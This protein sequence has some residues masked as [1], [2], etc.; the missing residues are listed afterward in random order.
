MRY[1]APQ[2]IREA[3]E[4]DPN[5]VSRNRHSL[6]ANR[7]YRRR[8]RMRH[9]LR[10]ALAKPF[11]AQERKHSDSAFSITQRLNDFLGRTV[12]MFTPSKA[13]A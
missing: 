12:R 1:R 3:R 6:G 13:H 8:I 4:A 9:L 11:A 7:Q 10:E 5:W 2:Y